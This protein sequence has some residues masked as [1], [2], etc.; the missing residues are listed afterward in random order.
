MNILLPM[1]SRQQR[2]NGL[3]QRIEE[4]A[5]DPDYKEYV[6]VSLFSINKKTYGAL[7]VVIEKRFLFF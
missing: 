1:M 5:S 4:L 7:S 2:S 3:T 6:K